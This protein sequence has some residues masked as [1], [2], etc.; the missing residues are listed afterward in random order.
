MC[1]YGFDVLEVYGDFVLLF[2][3]IFVFL[4]VF[5][6]CDFIL[7]MYWCD[8]VFG[9]Y[10]LYVVLVFIYWCVIVDLVWWSWWVFFSLLYG[11]I[12][13]E[14]F[15]VLVVY[16]W[17]SNFELI[18]KFEDYYVFV[19]CDFVIWDDVGSVLNVDIL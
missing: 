14:V 3:K 4:I 9:L 13:V 18:L 1:V 15:G 2:L 10:W 8:V 6:D 19:N 7:I 16:V 5:K 12:V 11:L 17:F